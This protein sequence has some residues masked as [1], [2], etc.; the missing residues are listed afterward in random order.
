MVKINTKQTHFPFFIV[1]LYFVILF[2]SDVGLED[3]YFMKKDEHLVSFQLYHKLD[4]S[5]VCGCGVSS[6][7]CAV[8]L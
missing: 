6:K 4:T 1:Q 8:F 7:M 2:V 3:G 5:Q